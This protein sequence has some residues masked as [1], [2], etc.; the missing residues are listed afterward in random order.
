MEDSKRKYNFQDFKLKIQRTPINSRAYQSRWGYRM[1]ESV[2][3][4]FTLEEILQIIRDGDLESVRQLSRYFYRTNSNYHNNVDFLAHLPLYDT[5]IV[6]IF[7]E[8]K[9]SEAQI[10]K[11]FYAACRYIDQ[12]DCPNLLPHITTEWILTGIYNGILRE[13]EQGKPVVQDLPLEYCRTRFKDFNNLNILEFNLTYFEHFTDKKTREE[14][15]LT[16]PKVVQQGWKLWQNHKNNV[17]T[18]IAIPPELGGIC[19]CFP[20]DLMPLLI[21]SIPELKKLDDAIKREETRDEN[22]L[23]KLLIQ[24][25]PIDKNGE[26]VFQLEEVADIHESVANMLKDEDTVEVL[27]TF[28]ETSLENLQDSSA[29]SQ[30]TDRLEKY[31][32]NVWDALGRGEILFNATNSSSLAYSIK[33]DETLMLAYIN[34][35]E[36]WIKYILNTRFSRKNLFFDFEILPTTRFNQT[37]MQSTYFRGAQYGY[38]K[39]F[40]GVAMGIKQMDQLSLM[41]FENNFLHMSEKMVP[42]QSSYTTSG[43]TIA[44]NEKK[45][46]TSEQNEVTSQATSDISDTGGRPEL[47]DEQKS[48]K[49]Q[50]NIDSQS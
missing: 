15:L 38:S 49:T 50:S 20:T 43:K 35:Y 37:D 16:F 6:P 32:K 25:M 39:M 44:E 21:A 30:S 45:S 19:F 47:P 33:K 40:A 2:K 4:D 9:G 7:E 10:L 48:E 3:T 14:V 31:R 26:L 41:N 29:A 27:T 8:G 17:E 34:V 1:N 11:N 46:S 36:T 24:R 13:D 28:G 5:V 12:L 18:W 42:L 22:E 23:Y